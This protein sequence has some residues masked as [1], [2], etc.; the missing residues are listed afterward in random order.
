[1]TNLRQ[2]DALT[3]CKLAL[4]RAA[5]GLKENIDAELVTVDLLEA[6][7]AAGSVDGASATAEVVD[8]IFS[9]FCVGK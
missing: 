4:E 1:M 7:S 5:D 3:K 6:L 9:R 8:G 2:F